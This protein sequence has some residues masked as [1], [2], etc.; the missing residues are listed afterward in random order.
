MTSKRFKYLDYIRVVSCIAVLLYHIGILKGGYLAV[1]IFF[2]LSGYLSVVSAFKKEKFS[3]KDYYFNRF[4]KLYIPLILCVFI[5]VVAVTYLSNLNWINLKP[6][7]TSIILGYNNYWQLNASL[8]YFVRNVSSPFM[9]LWYIAILLQFELLFPLLFIIFKNIG[10]KVNK[11]VPC[12]LLFILGSLSYYLFYRSIID[13]NIMNAYYGSLER[14]FSLLFGLLLGFVHTNYHPLVYKSSTVNK[15]LFYLYLIILVAMFIIIDSGSPLFNY[16][17]IISTFMGLR[18]IDFAVSIDNNLPNKVTSYI[19]N[20]SYEIYL[21]QYPVIFLFSDININNALKIVLIIL[22][23][24]LVSVIIH[25][26]LNI[27]K[28][29]KL[30]VFRIILLSML[31]LVGIFGIYK[32]VIAKDYTED[33]KR[34]EEELNSNRKLIEEKQKEYME[35]QATEEDDWEEFLN[36][37]EINEEELKE[38]IRNLK[39]VGIGDSV[40]HLA[41]KDLYIEFPNGYFDAAVNRTEHAI[42][43]MLKDWNS[44]GILGDVILFNLGTNGECSAKCKEEYMKY[45]GDRTVFWVNATNPDFASFNP[46][47]IEFAKKHPNIHIID[48]ISV[49]KD[50]PEYLIYDKVHPTVTGCKVYAKTIYDSIY[51]YY[52]NEYKTAREEKINEH[53]EYEKSKITFIGNDLLSGIYDQLGEYYSNK[54]YIISSSTSYDSLIEDLKDEELSNNIVLVFDKSLELSS[55]DYDSLIKYL[56]DRSIYIINTNNISIKEYENVNVID[57]SDENYYTFDRIHLNDDGNA[58]L[59]EF[60]KEKVIEESKQK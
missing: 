34:L 30:K 1:C 47:L 31:S 57:M 18:L 56:G 45:I 27:K 58:K 52:L 55:D 39:I 7:V 22:I 10:K 9:H 46:N 35:R 6:E 53:E 24:L 48:W 13:G 54:K 2:A 21:V 51:E 29:S 37:S 42:I 15:V 41:L 4:I 40:M 26:S 36:S 23:T 17:M 12:I 14:S 25:F 11:I 60:I 50:H 32:Y 59:F 3:L 28:T 19:S 5:S 20:I 38:R 33:M 43:D 16:S 49:T 44:K 8:D